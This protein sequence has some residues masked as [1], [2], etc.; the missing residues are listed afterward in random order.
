MKRVREFVTSL[1]MVAALATACATSE[2]TPADV[3]PTGVTDQKEA[4][5]II[6]KDSGST[7][8]DTG[9]TVTKTCASNCKTDSECQTTCPA[10]PNGGLNCCD[11]GS[12]VCYA[13]SS[14]TCGGV[15]AG[16][17]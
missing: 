13:S 3:T 5:S 11:T 10:A 9:T 7:T 4:G 1:L 17:D 6:P 2:E 8:Q 12:G 16:T 15:D 14:S